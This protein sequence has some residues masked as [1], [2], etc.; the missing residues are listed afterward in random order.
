MYDPTKS[1]KQGIKY[2]FFLG[3]MKHAGS[4]SKK[5]KHVAL[6][7]VVV[8]CAQRFIGDERSLYKKKKI[9]TIPESE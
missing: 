2:Y 4:H 9:A 5:K 6:W 3:D 8:L 1:T 7:L